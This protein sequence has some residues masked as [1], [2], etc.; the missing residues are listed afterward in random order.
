MFFFHR[1]FLHAHKKNKSEKQHQSGSISQHLETLTADSLLK[2]SKLAWVEPK[3]KQQSHKRQVLAIV[4]EFQNI[5]VAVTRLIT[6]QV[7]HTP[8]ARFGRIKSMLPR[9]QLATAQVL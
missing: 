2:G 5:V 6:M 4:C 9:R 1:L 8:T 7:T 3:I